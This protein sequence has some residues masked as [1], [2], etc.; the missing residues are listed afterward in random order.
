V[1]IVEL[2]YGDDG[3]AMIVVW[4]D[5]VDG[6][7]ALEERLSA[8][9]LEGWLS[10]LA[11]RE[12]KVDLPRFQIKS[13]FGLNEVMQ[14]LGVR[15]AFNPGEA[16]LT[17]ISSSGELYLSAAVHEAFVDVNEE[18]TEA[19]GATGQA[20]SAFSEPPEPDTF[21]AD[22]PF[23]FM[24]RDR[25][26]GSILFLG[27][28]VNPQPAPAT[29]PRA[30]GEQ[31]AQRAIDQG[32]LGMR[33]VG[34]PRPDF[35]AYAK[36]LKEKYGID[37]VWTLGDLITAE[38]EAQFERANGYNKRM[39]EAIRARFGE[40]DF[41]KLWEAAARKFFEKPLFEPAD[42]PAAAGEKQDE[43]ER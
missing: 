6:L 20:V 4:P 18:G 40:I 11:M 8:E 33:M 21:R 27:R 26:T 14:S 3:L 34:I 9:Q 10:Q 2:P 41:D 36:L 24:I 5:D 42:D 35:P 15:R 25:G 17:G 29:G 31:E 22:H 32:R 39:M 23:A 30:E 12:L 1:Q 38:N 37:A 43:V 28:V 13:H 19:A 7:A 16:D